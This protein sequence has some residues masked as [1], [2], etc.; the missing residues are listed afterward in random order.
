MN[1]PVGWPVGSA[2]H[3]FVW[4]LGSNHAQSYSNSCL[5]KS[6][7][8]DL[9]EEVLHFFTGGA[10]SGRWR[11]QFNVFRLAKV[12]VNGVFWACEICFSCGS[13]I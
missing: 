10:G 7:L 2:T 9:R 5:S 11:S 13:R 1:Q 4:P 12:K 3:L 6:A 8:I